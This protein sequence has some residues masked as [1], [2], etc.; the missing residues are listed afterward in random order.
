MKASPHILQKEDVSTQE[1]VP[2]RLKQEEE[3]FRRQRR[4]LQQQ[5]RGM[6]SFI[7]DVAFILFV[8]MCPDPLPCHA[9]LTHQQVHS[10]QKGLSVADIEDRY[11]SAS[12]DHINAIHN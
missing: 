8:W 6:E 9:Y 7:A 10:D 11:L 2:E 3:R 4:A 1:S 5:E 12:I